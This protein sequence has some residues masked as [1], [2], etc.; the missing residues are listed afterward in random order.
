MR[1]A[2][3]D[4]ELGSWRRMTNLR[5]K[6][7]ASRCLRKSRI[8]RLPIKTVLTRPRKAMSETLHFSEARIASTR[9][10]LN[11]SVRS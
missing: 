1:E 2:E 11:E 6:K 4:P 3:V 7:A 9:H 10:N 5:C 8:L